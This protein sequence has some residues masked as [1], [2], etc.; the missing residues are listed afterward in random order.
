MLEKKVT[1]RDVAKEAGVSQS[2]VSL[3]LNNTPEKKIKPETREHVLTVAKKMGYRVNISARSMKS[4]SAFAIGLLSTWNENSFVFPPVINGVKAMANK[5]DL[6]VVVCSGIKNT[7][8]SYDFVDYYMQNRID[9]LIYIS[10]VGVK[11]DGVIEELLNADIPFVCIIGARDIDEVSGV[12]INF[13]ENGYIAA[14]HIG[15]CGYK[16]I[17]Y[18]LWNKEQDLSYAEKE[19]LLGARDAAAQK[20]CSFGVI[21]ELVEVQGE[22]NL[23]K[24]AT[25][26]IES[27]AYDSIIGTSYMCFIF[28]K[29]AARKGIKVPEELGVISLDNDLFAQYLYPSLTTVDEPLSDMAQIASQLLIEKIKGDKECVKLE[30]NPTLNIREST[31]RIE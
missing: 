8:G 12:D 30:L 14:K 21:E 27:K 3:I 24:K 23:I 5:N 1:S 9:G 19:R 18:I 10:Y 20:G 11:K 4:K 2:L 7:S 28:L 29:A 13:I 16:R 25:N 15:E 31:R 17:G 6:G 22:E 26:I